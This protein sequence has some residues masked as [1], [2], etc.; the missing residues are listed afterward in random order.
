MFTDENDNLW[1]SVEESDIYQNYQIFDVFNKNGVFLNR[2]NIP[3]LKG[4]LL[5]SSW[6]KIVA[7]TSEDYEK[8]EE[9]DFAIKIV[10]L[11]IY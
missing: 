8:I 1:V 6:N 9:T 7:V 10:K 5:K 3:E 2:F 4:M 11:K